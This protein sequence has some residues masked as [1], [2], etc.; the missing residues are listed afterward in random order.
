MKKQLLALSLLLAPV[1]A[2]AA[3]L[4]MTLQRGDEIQK[5]TRVL[6]VGEHLIHEEGPLA[7]D[8]EAILENESGAKGKVTLSMKDENGQLHVLGEYEVEVEIGR[9]HV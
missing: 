7:L 5:E 2:S 4:E 6:L 8:L 3:R 1:W 9:A